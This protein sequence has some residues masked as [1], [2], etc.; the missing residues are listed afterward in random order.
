MGGPKYLNCPVSISKRWRTTDIF[1][2][3]QPGDSHAIPTSGPLCAFA[4]LALGAPPVAAA[5]ARR[6]RRSASL[7]PAVFSPVH[8][9]PARPS[10]LS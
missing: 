1:R 9:E 6:R 4:P 5:R 7:A 3:R 2:I 10:A 8:L